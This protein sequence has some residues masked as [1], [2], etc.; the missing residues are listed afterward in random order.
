VVG[1]AAARGTSALS[2]LVEVPAGVP[3]LTC[4]ARAF[5]KGRDMKKTTVRALRA[6]ATGQREISEQA[7]RERRRIIK[8]VCDRLVGDLDISLQ[9][10]RE[11]CLALAPGSR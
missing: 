10:V 6:G 3:R 9:Q 5:R 2:R 11:V 1:G 7:P 8:S 4:Q